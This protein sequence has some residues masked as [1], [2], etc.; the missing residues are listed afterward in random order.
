M[1]IFGPLL[2]ALFLAS[3]VFAQQMVPSRMFCGPQEVFLKKL[4]ES[5]KEAPTALGIINDGQAILSIYRSAD[6]STWTVMMTNPTTKVMCLLASG[7]DY[8]DVNWHLKPTGP[9]T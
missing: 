5:I 2:I 1:K 7:T 8:Q 9:K 6:G 3:P 4:T